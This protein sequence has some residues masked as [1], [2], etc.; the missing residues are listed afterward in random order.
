VSTS[1]ER[2]PVFSEAWARACAEILNRQDGYRTA[3]ASWEVTVMLTMSS[4]EADG[5][6]RRVF[7]DL[8]R[9]ECRE[10]RAAGPEDEAQARYILSGTVVAWQQVLTGAMAPLHAIMTGKVRL[11]KGSLL[12]LLPYVNAA[13]ELVAAASL[14]QASFPE[15]A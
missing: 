2:F 11:T 10:A 7:L 3:A 12:E 9:G 8:W 15:S 14:V 1:P 13:R 5:S 6:E 4:I